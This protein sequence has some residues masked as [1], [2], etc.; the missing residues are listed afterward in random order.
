M[1]AISSHI[2]SFIF[3]VT[4]SLL[5]LF[6]HRKRS[7]KILILTIIT[8]GLTDVIAARVIKPI[9]KR[10]RPTHDIEFINVTN[11]HLHQNDDGTY[12]YGGA[13]GFPSN[14]AANFMAMAIIFSFFLKNKFKYHSSTILFIFLITFLVGYSRCYLAVH[15]PSDVLAGWIFGLLVSFVSIFFY[16]HFVKRVT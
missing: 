12:Y 5:I 15:Y 3:F 8:I 10:P 6:L 14:H 13:Y 1:W 9:F 4:L 7:W 2:F 16:K 11:L